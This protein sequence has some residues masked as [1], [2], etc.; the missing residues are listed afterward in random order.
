MHPVPETEVSASRGMVVSNGVVGVGYPEGSGCDV[1]VLQA[2]AALHKYGQ[3]VLNDVPWKT[4]QNDF[5]VLEM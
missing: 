1:I 5:W 4:M 2:G 3:V